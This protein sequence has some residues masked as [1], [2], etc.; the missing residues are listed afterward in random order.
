MDKQIETALREAAKSA[1]ALDTDVVAFDL[2][3]DIVAKVIVDE[4]GVVHGA[5]EAVGEMKRLRPRFFRETDWN[6]MDDERYREAED[7]FRQG[8]RRPRSF[9]VADDFKALDASRLSAVELDALSKAVGGQ[10]NAFDRGLLTRALARQ[11]AEDASL[12]GGAK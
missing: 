1:Q 7:A 6:K 12:Q 11:R 5:R 3:Q 10:I 2:F 4:N 8:L 9:G